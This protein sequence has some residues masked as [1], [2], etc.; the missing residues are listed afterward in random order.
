MGCCLSL[1]EPVTV[2]D[3]E[4]LRL[5]YGLWVH[6]GIPDADAIGRRWDIF[7]A[8]PMPDPASASTSR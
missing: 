7:A 5:R 6:D 2:A 8:L 3:G 1:D 4:T